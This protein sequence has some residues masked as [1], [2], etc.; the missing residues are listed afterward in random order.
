MRETLARLYF[1]KDFAVSPVRRP[2]AELGLIAATVLAL[3]QRC[4]KH[5]EI[6]F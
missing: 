3:I 6:A 1:R 4:K 2:D 5:F